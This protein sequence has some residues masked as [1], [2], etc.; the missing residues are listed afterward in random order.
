[1]GSP[2]QRPCSWC[3]GSGEVRTGPA[4][5]TREKCDVCRGLGYLVMDSDAFACPE[6]GGTGEV[7]ESEGLL[8]VI[9]GSERRCPRCKGTG[10]A[11][12]A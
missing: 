8:D 10:W 11:M 6:C 7:T 9:L 12:P 2:V 4:S 3:S 5:A 1:M